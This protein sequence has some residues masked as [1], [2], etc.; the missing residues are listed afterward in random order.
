MKKIILFSTL[1]FVSL[2]TISAQDFTAMA[3]IKLDKEEDYRNSEEELKQC[4]K[5]LNEVGLDGNEISRQYAKMFAMRWLIGSPYVTLEIGPIATKLAKKNPDLLIN[6]MGG[7]TLAALE[8]PETTAEEGNL[9]GVRTVY[10]YV[11][12]GNAVKLDGTLKKLMKAGDAGE[13]EAWIEK[14]Q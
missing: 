13:L 2:S 5:Y 9:A 6:Y 10:E 8:N 11:K 4:I 1:I 14:M 7:W 12:A 3:N